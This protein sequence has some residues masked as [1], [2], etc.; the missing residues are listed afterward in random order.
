MAYLG[1]NRRLIGGF[2]DGSD[3]KEFAC[4]TGDPGSILCRNDPVE[5]GRATH[6]SIL[7]WRIDEQKSL[8]GYSPWGNKE[9]DTTE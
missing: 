5:K 6:S 1:K 2:P 9:S 4:N 3:D 8:V 7:V